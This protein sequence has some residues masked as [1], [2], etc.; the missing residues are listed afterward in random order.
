MTNSYQTVL[1]PVDDLVWRQ[2]C[3]EGRRVFHTLSSRSSLHVCFVE[4]IVD[5]LFLIVSRTDEN[6]T[7]FTACRAGMPS[8]RKGR[9]YYYAAHVAAKKVSHG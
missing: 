4:V 3:A 8:L 9:Q 2:L 5:D 1:I 7:V 6:W